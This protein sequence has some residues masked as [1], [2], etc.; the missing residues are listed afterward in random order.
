METTFLDSVKAAFQWRPRILKPNLAKF[1]EYQTVKFKTFLEIANTGN[2]SLMLVSGKATETEL[3]TEWEK[4][5]IERAKHSTNRS[6][7]MYL[8]KYRS[9][10]MLKA[11]YVV[12]RAMLEKLGLGVDFSS[13]KIKNDLFLGLDVE[14]LTEMRNRGYK[15]STKSDELFRSTL[16]S[17]WSKYNNLI[18]KIKSAEI[19]LNLTLSTMDNKPATYAQ[20]MARLRVDLKP[21]VIPEDL[22]LAEFDAYDKIREE[23]RQTEKK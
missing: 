6:Y 12:E 22:T 4:I 5:I 8:E 21:T 17:S 15:L 14:T 18:S 9:V 20:I 23:M 13:R 10:A 7:N 11:R 1:Y 19:S 2:Y 16:L 3:E